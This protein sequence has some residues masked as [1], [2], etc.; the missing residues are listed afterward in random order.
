MTENELIENL[1]VKVKANAEKITNPKTDDDYFRKG[2]AA[3]IDE[4]HEKALEYY[5]KV[6]ELNPKHTKAYNQMGIS[7][8]HLGKFEKALISYKK[9]IETNPDDLETL[10]SGCIGLGNI[11]QDLGNE[12]KA[13]EFQE[14]F[15]WLFLG[16]IDKMRKENNLK[17]LS[18]LKN[19]ILN[20]QKREEFQSNRKQGNNRLSKR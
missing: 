18:E 9:E 5:Q 4:N 17:I 12:A 7:Y 2:Y 3:K 14:I 16:Y 10:I 1:K 6:I 15:F 20:G 19:L 8:H 11:Y 13:K